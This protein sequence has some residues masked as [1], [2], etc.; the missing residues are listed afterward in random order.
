MWQLERMYLIMVATALE[1]IDHNLV[2]GSLENGKQ[3][4]VHPLSTASTKEW[5][6]PGFKF[7]FQNLSSETL[8]KLLWPNSTMRQG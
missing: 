3:G 4:A 1:V 5:D 6:R 8:S 2:A 7:K